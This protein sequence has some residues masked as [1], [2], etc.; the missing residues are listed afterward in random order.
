[1]SS[2]SV[3]LSSAQLPIM[4]M[5][6]EPDSFIIIHISVTFSAR[7]VAGSIENSTTTLFRTK[8]IIHHLLSIIHNA[9]NEY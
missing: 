7:P 8:T 2:S 1:M 6:P 5:L 3:L 9:F 4:S